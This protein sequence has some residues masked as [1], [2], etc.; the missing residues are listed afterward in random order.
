[1]NFIAVQVLVKPGELHQ[2][3]PGIH[4]I[5]SSACSS[6]AGITSAGTATRKEGQSW[7]CW[8]EAAPGGLQTK[9]AGLLLALG[10]LSSGFAQ[11]SP[12]NIQG[13]DSSPLQGTSPLLCSHPADGNK[14]QVEMSTMLRTAPSGTALRYGAMADT[15]DVRAWW[16]KMGHDRCS[17]W[18]LHGTAPAGTAGMPYMCLS[19][20]FTYPLR[21]ECN[22]TC[23]VHTPK[24]SWR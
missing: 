23:A 18:L 22:Q 2:C 4:H 17:H 9:R 19:I 21:C 3:E 15:T 13:W 14:E 10:Q 8:L 24:E 11:S 7:R 5:S 1:M 16:R 6:R 12:S 20:G